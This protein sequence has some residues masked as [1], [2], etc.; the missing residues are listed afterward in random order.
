[1][2]RPVSLAPV[3]PQSIYEPLAAL[4]DPAAAELVINNVAPRAVQVRYTIY[5]LA[6]ESV[7]TGDLSLAPVEVRYL[8][9]AELLQ[10]ID[11]KGHRELGGISLSY[12]GW[13][14]GVLGQILY[15]G[16][17]AR[18]SVDGVFFHVTDL[19][20]NTQSATWSMPP[21]SK[22]TLILG[23]SSDSVLSA[24][25]SLDGH[26]Q[27]DITIS[28]HATRLVQLE[29]GE[30]VG[31]HFA[32]V[33]YIGPRGT[34]RETG[35]ILGD[36]GYAAPIR[37]YD[38]EDSP[39][40]DLFATGLPLRNATVTMTLLNTGT[41]E[42]TA[43][44]HLFPVGSQTQTPVALD[45]IRLGVGQSAM[46]SLN[47]THVPLLGI[48]TDMVSVHI[49]SNGQPGDLIG[50]LVSERLDEASNDVEVAEVPLRVAGNPG[51]STG[52]YPLRLDDDFTS[53]VTI[54]NAGSE[55]RKY[56][57]YLQMMPSGK[58]VFPVSSLAPGETALFDIN[59]IR[60]GHQ[61]D[62]FGHTLMP[63]LKTAKFVWSIASPFG[64]DRMIGRA[65][66]RSSSNSISASFS[67]GI[68]CPNVCQGPFVDPNLPAGLGF[69][70]SSSGSVWQ[71]RNDAYGNITN[72]PT[73]LNGSFDTTNIVSD[74]ESSG[75]YQMTGLNLGSTNLNYLFTWADIQFDSVDCFVDGPFTQTETNPI[76]VLSVTFSNPPPNFVV[77]GQTATLAA[78]VTPTNNS[79][80]ISLS[81]SSPAALVSPTG[82]FTA[83]TNVVVKGLTVGTATLNATI[84]NLDGGTPITVGST[85][86]PVT[87][88]APTAI[89]A[90]R[91]SATV[92][93]DDAAKSSYQTAEGTINLGPIIASGKLTGCFIGSEGVGT[94]TPSNYTGSVTLHRVI[95]RDATY[96]NS[97]STGG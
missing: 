71:E 9:V 74:S 60:D 59:E 44:P 20:S 43:R 56:S 78:T 82:T 2:R 46:L 31:A 58:Y 49:E 12:D 8:R 63:D 97:T 38:R 89:V 22:T 40:A 47:S 85:S 39:Q 29:G 75:T 77:I 34:L 13:V 24:K 57:A 10:N 72:Y 95:I 5:S 26:G 27:R 30:Q 17:K 19:P 70:T 18:N 69:G 32:T 64:E 25:L 52:S 55:E 91:T 33:S 92:S 6:G 35:Y 37:F 67:C 66:V 42:V 79:T 7:V 65:Y 84:P 45:A 73:Y 76:D 61:K 21:H 4:D 23:N 16:G 96:T 3:T 54:T 15:L 68:P 50:S 28:A 94:I 88:A 90:L 36:N 48:S 11:D 41:A 87:S 83:N 80:P 81:I 51:Q 93:S 62:A 1:L 53:Q 14:K 86:L